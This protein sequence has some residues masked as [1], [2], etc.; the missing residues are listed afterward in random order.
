MFLQFLGHKDSNNYSNRQTNP[1]KSFILLF[2][3]FG[4]KITQK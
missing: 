1:K 4:D 3:Q 2:S